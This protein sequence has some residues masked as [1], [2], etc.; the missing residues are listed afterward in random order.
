[1][2]KKKIILIISILILFSTI[3]AISASDNNTTL[4]ESKDQT[5]TIDDHS[6]NSLN[7]QI[8]TADSTLKI[9]G[10]YK[11][12]PNT[13]SNL[14]NGVIINKNMKIIGKSKTVIDGKSLA[15]CIYITN[16]A[17]VTLENL[18]IQNGYSK[19]NGA[20]IYISSG[21]TVIIKNCVFKNNK[22]FNANGGAIYSHQNVKLKVY[23]S[24]FYNNIAVRH[25][26]L[27]WDDYKR[28]MGSAIKTSIKNT[29]SIRDSTFKN[30]KAY[31]ATV[32]VV[33]YTD[34]V[35]KPSKLYINKCRFE[36]NYSKHSGVIYLDEFGSGKILNSI[37]K[38]NKSPKGS[39][40]IVLDTSKSAVVKNCKFYRNTGLDGGGIC[41]KVF[42]ENLRSHVK[43]TKCT[44]YKNRA[45]HTG[46]A[47]YS[48]G[49]K[50]KIIK[51]KFIKNKAKKGGAIYTRMTSLKIISTKFR[52]NKASKGKNI[53]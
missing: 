35:K 6:F 40:I 43:L 8:K 41:I 9:S 2:L 5:I 23:S 27:K 51:C 20:G 28:G 1:M 53:Y 25:S 30:N 47:V 32:L 11:Y 15:R 4:L 39:G 24:K 12:N 31:L 19:S 14:K 21:S 26:N 13:D 22:V 49:G 44:F 33:S 18:I 52:K 3:S 50:L 34:H 10:T 7:N 42:K 16:K 45:Y 17:T 46:G 48:V 29:V 38:K 36:K 37:F